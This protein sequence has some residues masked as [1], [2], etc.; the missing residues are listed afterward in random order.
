[1]L[2]CS[3]FN[4]LYLLIKHHAS[5]DLVPVYAYNFQLKILVLEGFVLVS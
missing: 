4:K 2:N 5:E 1:M 3:Y